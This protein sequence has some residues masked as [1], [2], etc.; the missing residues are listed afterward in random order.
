MIGIPQ[1]LAEAAC[2]L[3]S[4]KSSWVTGQI[5]NVNGGFGNLD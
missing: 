3:L 4:D 5:M 1:Y 2:Y